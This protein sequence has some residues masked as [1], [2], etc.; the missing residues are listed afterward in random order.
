MPHGRRLKG[1]R[2]QYG[3]DKD[4]QGQGPSSTTVSLLHGANSYLFLLKG[5]G[6]EVYWYGNANLCLFDT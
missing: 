2:R 6:K 5:S 4:Q 3:Q 1:V